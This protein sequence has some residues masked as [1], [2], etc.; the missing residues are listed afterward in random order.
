MSEQKVFHIAFSVRTK[1]PGCVLIQAAMGG[2]VP[3]RLFD[4]LFPSEVWIAGGE[5][6]APGAF[7]D[8]R[9]YPAS[10][11]QLTSLSIMARQARESQLAALKQR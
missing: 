6:E 4:E 7:D 1:R 10:R 11:D 2:D 5:P 8:M 9:L 3:S